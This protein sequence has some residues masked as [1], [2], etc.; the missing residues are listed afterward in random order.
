MRAAS[1][2]LARS[3][4]IES[5]CV[6]VCRWAVSV[7]ILRIELSLF[8]VLRFGVWVWGVG[9]GGMGWRWNERVREIRRRKKRRKSIYVVE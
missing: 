7:Y 8:F 3:F 2:S 9:W 5:G 1:M 4:G 6:L